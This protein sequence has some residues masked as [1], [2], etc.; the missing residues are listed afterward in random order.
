MPT[1]KQ[2][3]D[4]TQLCGDHASDDLIAYFEQV[5][6]MQ[7]AEQV[8]LLAPKE[9]ISLTKKFRSFH[10]VAAKLAGIV[11]DDPDTSNHHLLVTAAACAGSVLYLDHD[12]ETRIVYADLESFRA[13]AEQAIEEDSLVCD[14]HEPGGVVVDDQTSLGT[15]IAELLEEGD[16]E[17]I[18]VILALIPSLDLKDKKLLTELASSSDFYLVEAV[19]MAITE[20]PK[21]SLKPIAELCAKH[22]HPQ[23]ARAG[24]QALAKIPAK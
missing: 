9:S 1:P 16:E 19:A 6:A 10:P 20:R 14:L 5:E 8:N 2:L 7:P 21:K 24:K 15:A 22:K 23:A 17:S 11:L 4:L 12:G 3:K 18:A 13:A